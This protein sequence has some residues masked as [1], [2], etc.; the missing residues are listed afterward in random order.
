MTASEQTRLAAYLNSTPHLS[1]RKQSEALNVSERQLL[2]LLK[3]LR[4][5]GLAEVRQSGFRPRPLA[6][7]EV[8]S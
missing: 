3:E 7:P 8:A 5:A 2:L 1:R 6:I 4:E